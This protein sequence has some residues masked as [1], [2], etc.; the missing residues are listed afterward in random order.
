VKQSKCLF[1]YINPNKMH[2]SLSSFCL[3]T[4]LHVS[5]ITITHLQEHKTTVT[6]ASGNRYTVLLSGVR[7]P[8][9]TQISSNSSTIAADNSTG[10][11]IIHYSVELTAFSAEYTLFSNCNFNLV[12]RHSLSVKFN[13]V[14]YS[15][16][17]T[18]Y[19]SYKCFVLLKM[20]DSETQNM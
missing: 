10:T 15:V 20:D 12:Y 13:S 19:C 5:G 11:Y 18:R 14:Y 6:T 1:K 17:L 2:K 3:R 7:H 4:A 8:Q 9:H 16:M